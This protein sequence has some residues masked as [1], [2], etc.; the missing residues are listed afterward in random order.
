[1]GPEA[2]NPREH[3][4]DDHEKWQKHVEQ[5]RSWIPPIHRVEESPQ[6]HR[7]ASGQDKDW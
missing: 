3:H 4:D 7:E 2:G 1:M 5:A 6:D